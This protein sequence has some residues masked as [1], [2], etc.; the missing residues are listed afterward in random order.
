[1]KQPSHTP[2]PGTVKERDWYQKPDYG[3]APPYLEENR[4]QVE[5]TAMQRSQ[6]TLSLLEARRQEVW[7]AK[8]RILRVARRPNTQGEGFG[9]VV[10]PPRRH[11]EPA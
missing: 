11:G 9:A 7:G 8:I 2:W 1:M 10:R 4:S 6:S 5:E 3:I